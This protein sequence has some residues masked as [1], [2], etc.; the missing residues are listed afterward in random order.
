MA[1]MTTLMRLSMAGVLMGCAT[2]AMAQ[3][4]PIVLPGAPGQA[5]RV[6]TAGEATNVTPEVSVSV[7]LP[8]TLTLFNGERFAPRCSISEGA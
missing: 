4:P 8:T 1:L 5:P 6:V 2:A 7:L 3:D